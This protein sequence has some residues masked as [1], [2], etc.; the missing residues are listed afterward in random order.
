[1]GCYDEDDMLEDI[2]K[3]RALCAE[4]GVELRNEAANVGH[5]RSRRPSEVAFASRL[6]ALADRLEGAAG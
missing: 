6:F 1:M 3:L 2:R 5:V 4:V